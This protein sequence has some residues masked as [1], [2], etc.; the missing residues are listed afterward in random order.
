[1]GQSDLSGVHRI[2]GQAIKRKRI[3]SMW[4]RLFSLH[5][6]Y[7]LILLAS[8]LL[9]S[10]QFHTGAAV[11]DDPDIWWHLHNADQ[12]FT[13]HHPVRQDAY[14]YTLPGKPWIN[15]ETGA[16][17]PFYFANKAFGLSGIYYVSLLAADLVILGT[18][19]LAYVR[20]R[21]LNA[22]FLTSLISVFLLSPSVG[23]RTILFGWCC[24]IVELLILE[25]H[26]QGRD[27]LWLLPPL[28][29]LWINVH[30]SYLIGI[31]FLVLYIAGGVVQG[32]WGR[33]FSRGWSRTEIHKLLAVLVLS[34]AGSFLNP[35]TWRL[36]FYPFDVALQQPI[37]T[38]LIED[39]QSLNFQ[40]PR[41]KVA[42]GLLSLFS[43]LHLSRSQRWPLHEG[44]FYLL[45]FY[46]AFTHQRF[47]V[48]LGI[49]VCPILASHI[50]V[51][52]Y[53]SKRDKPLLNAAA[54]AIVAGLVSW[55]LPDAR[56][57]KSALAQRY[58]VAAL[59]WLKQNPR[60]GHMFSTLEWGG[61]LNY[62]DPGTPVFMDGRMDIFEH[63]GVFGD[64][65]KIISVNGSLQILDRYRIESVLLPTG[66]P[67][68]YLLE[69]THEWVSAY[70]DDN[71]VV[72]VR[73]SQPRTRRAE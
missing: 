34:I 67:L 61:Y 40:D 18:F 47:L 17:L 20:T 71:A 22:S 66:T 30:A 48:M 11:F 24:L 10:N 8:P 52:P 49:V 70:G 38:R 27:Y 4:S 46:S 19:L 36:V 28:I 65:L 16:E 35:Y 69:H 14:S 55:L 68:V 21:N 63:A 42:F 43:L 29:V 60:R 23:P 6:V 64:Y 51:R 54:I 13:S 44:L 41:A 12:L 33:L 3:P 59:E 58:P 15:P 37:T 50:Q 9:I 62:K 7:L 57:M 53:Q 45:A 1:M 2:L 31:V 56:T 73:V 32:Q 5:S 72:L 25:L 26:H 39:W